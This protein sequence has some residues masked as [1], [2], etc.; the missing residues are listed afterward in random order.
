M[1]DLICDSSI[2]LDILQDHSN[3]ALQ[4]NLLSLR[5][6]CE[7]SDG[8]LFR[9]ME[10]VYFLTENHI[11]KCDVNFKKIK[12]I[13]LGKIKEC[14]NKG[15]ICKICNSKKKIFPFEH[16]KKKCPKCKT[17]YHEKCHKQLNCIKCAIPTNRNK[18]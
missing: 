12:K 6:F 3:L 18:T 5:N 11:S 14:Q 15:V 2:M 8:S 9:F 16:K 4:S 17:I 1:Y 7:I 13:L 10:R